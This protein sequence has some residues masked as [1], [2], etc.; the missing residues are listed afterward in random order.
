MVRCGDVNRE[1]K[2]DDKSSRQVTGVTI[3]PGFNQKFHHHFGLLFLETDF[4]LKEN[5]IN[6]VCLP[7][8]TRFKEYVR[9]NCV[10]TGWGNSVGNSGTF[11]IFLDPFILNLYTTSTIYVIQKFLI[12]KKH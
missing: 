9:D 4:V 2:M 10:A 12:F 7:T 1:G 3:H 11:L 5:E 6:V 8:D